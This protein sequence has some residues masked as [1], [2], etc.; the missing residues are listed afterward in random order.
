M[1]PIRF[2]RYLFRFT[3]SFSQSVYR[4][5]FPS[6]L[7]TVSHHFIF[8]KITALIALYRH[9][10][11]L[12]SYSSCEALLDSLSCTYIFSVRDLPHSFF[13]FSRSQPVLDDSSGKSGAKFYQSYDKLFIIK[14]LTSEEV[15]RMHSFLK[16]YHPVSV[17]VCARA[18]LDRVYLGVD[19]AI[20][21]QGCRCVVA[22]YRRTTRKDI[23]AA[24]S[25]NVPANRRR[26]RALRGR[27]TQCILESLD[28]SQ[29]VRSE[30]FDGGPRSVGQGE[31]EGPTHLQG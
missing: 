4:I 2:F 14:T 18:R 17:C 7:L 3:Y 22:V 29:E 26:R 6:A 27:H 10:I 21:R 25:G 12:V 9:F 15:E 16:Q 11:Y 20:S 5:C 30:G 8:I 23:V 31:G 13:L 19:L 24:I 28:D 1:V